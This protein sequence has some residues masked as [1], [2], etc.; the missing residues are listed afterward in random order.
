[1]CF[2]L[3]N[4]SILSYY[5]RLAARNFYIAEEA[6]QAGT[7]LDSEQY[8]LAHQQSPY[9]ARDNVPTPAPAPTKHNF[10]RERL[11]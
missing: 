9:Q 10:T 1:M 8:P 4:K 6:L 11:P 2:L 5:S 7:I 3:L